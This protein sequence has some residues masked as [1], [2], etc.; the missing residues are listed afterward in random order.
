MQARKQALEAPLNHVDVSIIM[1]VIFLLL[2]SGVISADSPV[3]HHAPLRGE[4]LSVTS[5]ESL[6]S[7]E[8][9]V[10]NEY[11]G[12]LDFGRRRCLAAR[13]MAS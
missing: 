11:D 4:F 12:E 2:G 9:S 8:S 5:K 7:L 1:G 10:E 3:S 13:R 6:E